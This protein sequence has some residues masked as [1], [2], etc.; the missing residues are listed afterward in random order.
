[1]GKLTNFIPNERIASAIYVIRGEKVMLD[2]DLAELYG[3]QT[4]VLNQAVKRNLDRF[5]EH[6]MFQLTEEEFENLKSQIATSNLKSHIVT[7]SEWGG[8]RSLPY[9]FTEHGALMLSSVLKSETAVKMGITVVETFVEMRKLLS[10]NEELARKVNEH[11]RHISNLYEH[12]ERLLKLP[13]SSSN[14]IGYIWQEE[15]KNA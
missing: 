5:P 11:D 8:R 13:K 2:S 3:V 14:P 7:S 12:I 4:R 15:N 6:F 9:A 10:S 1:M